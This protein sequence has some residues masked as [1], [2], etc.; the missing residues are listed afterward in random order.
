MTASSG[1]EESR[2]GD[3]SLCSGLVSI[4]G[5]RCALRRSP[6][7]DWGIAALSEG[8]LWTLIGLDFGWEIALLSEK[9]LWTGLVFGEINCWVR[10]HLPN[11]QWHQFDLW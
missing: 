8:V 1:D 6:D 3:P 4:I 11:R 5:D 9:V 7:S 2:Q 10:H